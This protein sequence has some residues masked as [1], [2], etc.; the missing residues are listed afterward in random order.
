MSE[1]TIEPEFLTIAELAKKIGMSKKFVEK[2]S[3]HNRIPGKKLFGRFIRFERAAI[4][5]ALLREE[6]LLPEPNGRGK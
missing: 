3:Q 5:R 2:H 4:D 6:F 1:I